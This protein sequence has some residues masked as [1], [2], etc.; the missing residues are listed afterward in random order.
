VQLQVLLSKGTRG[1][2]QAMARFKRSRYIIKPGLQMRYT[3]V[4]LLSL[5]LVSMVVGWTV[6]FTIWK[7]ISD[8]ALTNDQ[9]IDI[10]VRGNEILFWK[11]IVAVVFICFVSIF[12]SHKIAGPVY[13]FEE[14]ARTIANG[15][16]SYRIKLRKGDE[17][18]DLAIAFNRMTESLE[19][20]VQENNDILERVKK[21]V[22]TV[23]ID[24]DKKSLPAER[25]QEI[26]Q[27]LTFIQTEMTRIYDA[28]T[29]EDKEFDE[30]MPDIIEP[31]M[32]SKVSVVE[33]TTSS[34]EE[35]LS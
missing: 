3:G 34:D 13:R 26:L 15:D 28:F 2:I 25:K 8:P 14:S 19:S 12:V 35:K 6:Y 30:E 27:E 4:I 24:F 7:Q 33:D 23:K 16:F 20:I 9:L 31:A 17:L 21:T 10:F 5:F 32:V 29:V 11:M 22:D 18:H 1:G